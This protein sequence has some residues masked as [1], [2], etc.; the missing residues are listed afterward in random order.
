MAEPMPRMPF[1]LLVLM[2]AATFGG[3]LTFG[4][5]LRGGA[6][7]VW[8]PD[9]AVEWVMLA[10]TSSLVLVLMG[11][12]FWL[13]WSNLRDLKRAKDA[14]TVRGPGEKAAP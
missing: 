5:F 3:P 14:P 9:R 1:A 11:C 7:A 6:S 2:T 10:A 4:L 13:G 12:C 8:P